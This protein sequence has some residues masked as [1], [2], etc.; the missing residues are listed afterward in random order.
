VRI[1][2]ADILSYGLLDNHVAT[3]YVRPLIEKGL[4]GALELHVTPTTLLETYNTLYWHYKIRPRVK[5]ARKIWILAEG[6]ILLPSSPL[7]FKLATKEN[8]PLGDALLIATALENSIPIVVSNDKHIEKLAEKYGLIYENPI[9]E[10]VR[11]QIV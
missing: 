7:G 9:P 2:D 8:V 10:A 3:P 6:L 4:K 11:K 1:L 5:V